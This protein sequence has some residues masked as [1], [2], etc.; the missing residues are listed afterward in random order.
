MIQLALPHAE[1]LGQ[2]GGLGLNLNRRSLGR[3]GQGGRGLRRRLLARL[4]G[5]SRWER[6]LRGGVDRMRGVDAGIGR[7]LRR[8]GDR[9]PPAMIGLCSRHA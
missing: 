9:P 5:R 8:F 3:H 4:L 7:R 2:L 6:R 1:V